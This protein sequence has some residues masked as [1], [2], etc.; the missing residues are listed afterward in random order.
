MSRRRGNASCCTNDEGKPFRAALKG[1]VQTAINRLGLKGFPTRHTAKADRR[2]ALLAFMPVIESLPKRMQGA[3]RQ[4]AAKA[5]ISPR[6]RPQW[7]K[8]QPL[9]NFA[10]NTV[11]FL[12]VIDYWK[13]VRWIT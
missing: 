9:A 11:V 13:N 8:Q 10:I 12:N 4:L 3:N 5:T 6:Q 1:D 2:E 7:T